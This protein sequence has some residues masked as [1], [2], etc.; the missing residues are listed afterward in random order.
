ML[1]HDTLNKLKIR[2]ILLQV[3]EVKVAI[4]LIHLM[5]NSYRCILSQVLFKEDLRVEFILN[6][7]GEVLQFHMVNNGIWMVWYLYFL[8]EN[9]ISLNWSI[10]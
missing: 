6:R 3:Q 9:V 1:Q 8:K 4:Y 10:C 5:G 2:F 7:I